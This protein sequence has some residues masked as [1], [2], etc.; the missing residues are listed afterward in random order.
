MTGRRLSAFEALGRGLSNLRGNLAL[1][2]VSVAGALAVVALALLA[3]QPL[4]RQLGLS[5]ADVAA[6]GDPAR[7]AAV[8][9]DLDLARLLAG[10]LLVPMLLFLAG[11]TLASLV[12]CWFQ[13]G[14]LGV[15]AA[16]DAQAP[17][18]AGRPALAFRTYSTRFFS[19][20][21]ARLFGRL[22]AFYMLVLGVVI[23]GLAVV[24]LLVL[25]AGLAGGRWGGGAAFALGCGGA[26]PLFFGFFVLAIASTFGQADL[27]RADGSAHDALATGLR[28]LSRRLGASL[29]VYLL[30]T[31]AAVA[32]AVFQWGASTAAQ[33]AF[34]PT[35]A[36]GASAEVAIFLF[37]SLAG[38]LLGVGLAATAIA[39]V[40]AE[41][42]APEPAG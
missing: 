19:A 39:L 20:E 37:Q 2:A 21:A 8:F 7:V 9:Q 15:L 31:A 3:L 38:A 40:R 10:D 32:V 41:R 17:P 34:A 6:G 24:L 18:G 11:L 1:V 5:F 16:G 35:S 42:A 30:F 25:G 22:F 28:T 33:S 12:Q 36:A 14:I 26:I 29:G 13:A 23:A 4:F 27:P